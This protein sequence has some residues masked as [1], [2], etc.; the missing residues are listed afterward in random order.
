MAP[1]TSLA[2]LQIVIKKDPA[3]YYDDFL[4]QYQHFVHE[5]E[6]YKLRPLS[7]TETLVSLADFLNHTIIHYPKEVKE[8][9]STIFQMI[10]KQADQFEPTMRLKFFQSLM[11]T[12]KYAEI[13]SIVVIKLAFQT[14]NIFDKTLTRVLYDFIYKEIKYN[15]KTKVNL[16]FIRE[17]QGYCYEILESST[18]KV[19]KKMIEVVN[20]V[21]RKKI[22]IDA[23]TI[24]IVVSGCYH[25][26]HS[27]VQACIQ[28][29]LGIDLK[30]LA[31]EEEVKT[32]AKQSSGKMDINRHEHSKKTK[33][34]LR[35]VEKQK[36]K[37]KKNIK[38]QLEKDKEEGLI[39]PI[40]PALTLVHDPYKLADFLFGKLKKQNEKFEFKLLCMNL[41]SQLIGCHHLLLLGYYTYLQRYLT[42]HQQDVTKILAYFI[43]ACHDKIPADELLPMV[44][45]IAYTYISERSSNES[46]ALG[47]NTIR[48]IFI[49]VPAILLEDDMADFVQDL[50]QYAFKSHKVV[51]AAARSL[52]N[53]IR[54]KYPL[55]LKTKNIGK[56]TDKTRKPLQYGEQ[57][58]ITMEDLMRK[59][60]KEDSDEDGDE[61]SDEPDELVELDSDDEGVEGSGSE[62]EEEMDEDD[63]GWEDVSDEEDE[64]VDGEDGSGGWVSVSEGDEDGDEE[65]EEEGDGEEDS[66]EEEEEEKEEVEVVSRKRKHGHNKRL[67]V[68]KVLS[69]DDINL[70]EKMQKHSKQVKFQ[71]KEEE[72]ESSEEEEEEDSDFEGE[73]ENEALDYV[74]NPDRLLPTGRT[75]RASKIERLKSILSGRSDTKFEHEGHR[76]GLTN[77]EKL[78]KKNYVMV[79]RGKKDIHNKNRESLSIVRARNNS[80]VSTLMITFAHCSILIC[81]LFNVYRKS[82]MEETLEREGEHKMSCSFICTCMY[83][84]SKVLYNFFLLVL[85]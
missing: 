15:S 67:D 45:S 10:E 53:L 1:I 34:R 62:E 11:M 74:I 37:V 83:K 44:K 26:D 2:T 39:R 18:G 57:R 78:R 60:G 6:L 27:V 8:Y 33:K 12:Y 32:N 28:F 13:N 3:S 40:F 73:R 80:K 17:L 14:F 29:L 58:V 42:A 70:I 7:S 9:F 81:I 43:Q 38:A 77:K 41:V 48:E 4:R 20:E 84:S 35:D 51:M 21:Y 79:R 66:D 76:G 63:E 61:D 46:L 23:K 31:D 69:N 22:W 85:V 52:M 49:R 64:E 30:I 75:Q 55:L 68:N 50:V 65:D 24:N 71:D 25:Q 36:D 5:V 47:I 56:G 82:N 16:A 59:E 54:E 72:K 19:C